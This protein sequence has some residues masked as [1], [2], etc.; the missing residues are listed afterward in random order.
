MSIRA[1]PGRLG[2]PRFGSAIRAG[3]V[4]IKTCKQFSISTPFGGEK[5]SGM[6]AKGCNGIRAYMAQKSFY[7][8]LSGVPHPWAAAAVQAS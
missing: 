1:G 3:A 5:E 7:A 4:W 8:D 2:L 6:G